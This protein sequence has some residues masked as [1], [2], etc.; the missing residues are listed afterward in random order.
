MYRSLASAPRNDTGTYIPGTT[1][2][3]GQKDDISP[4]RIYVLVRD[5]NKI[6]PSKQGNRLIHF[7]PKK[8]LS[9]FATRFRVHGSRPD[10]DRC[11]RPGFPYRR[12]GVPPK[13]LGRRDMLEKVRKSQTYH[14]TIDPFKT[15]AS[16]GDKPLKLQVVYPQNGTAVLKG[17]K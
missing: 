15:A 12:V 1:I 3:K 13:V 9:G 4:I 17:F 11:V 6:K 7:R 14:I 16:F 5:K 8:S 2:K 10:L